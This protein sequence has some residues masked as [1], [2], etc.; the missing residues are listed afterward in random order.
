MTLHHKF[1]VPSF[2]RSMRS[3]LIIPAVCALLAVM[4]INLYMF[5]SL[6]RTIHNMNDLYATN[7]QLSQIEGELTDLSS[8]VN[9]Y[10]NTRS[11]EALL[12]YKTSCST[13]QN[14]V[15]Q[16]GGTISSN[17]SK[18]MEYDLKGL[19]DSYLKTAQ[20][21]VVMKVNGNDTAGDYRTEFVKAQHICS[22]MLSMIHSLD[23]L[24]FEANS[25]NYDSLYQSLILLE[26]FI[27]AMLLCITAYL[28]V[29]LYWIMGS[30]TEPLSILSE[31]ARQVQNGQ[32]DIEIPAPYYVDEV[33]TL[34]LTFSQMLAS[35]KQSIQEM[36]ESSQREMQMREKELMT[37]NLLKD[38]QI[39]YYQAQI[40]PHFLFN[41]LN[42]GQQ[43]AM[44]EDAEKTYLFMKSTAAFFRGQL[45]SNGAEA[46]I[47]EELDLIDHYIYIMNVRYS[48]EIHLN[49]HIDEKSLD[50]HFPGMVL[51]PI[52][53]NSLRYAFTDPDLEKIIDLSI[54]ESE[55]QCTIMIA[56]SGVGMPKGTL[57]RIR[58]GDLSHDEND[59]GNGVGIQN[60]RERL[61]LKYGSDS[62]FAIDSEEGGRNHGTVVT[63][64][65][66]IGGNNVQNTDC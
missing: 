43:L 64:R 12:D 36:K 14:T 17:P 46:T 9:I 61:K 21:A 20:K 49:K 26:R 18:S 47:Q 11:T 66:P 62:V 42:T 50:L 55:D 16:I 57:E 22:Y 8:N 24:R 56:D 33:G 4:V 19:A 52:V 3:R 39:K 31:K 34:T 38:A 63:I 28:A 13:F 15:E 37:E 40:N 45:R 29:L 30:V 1:Y 59:F 58:N 35:I 23:I 41:T 53:E 54:T 10:L 60:V 27:L 65:I 25:A 6:N 32:L 44:M 51:Q 48:G 5:G 7:V 2:F